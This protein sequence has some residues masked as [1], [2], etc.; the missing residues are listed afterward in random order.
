M[1]NHTQVYKLDLPVWLAR[2][3]VEL[4]CRDRRSRLRLTP[5]VP[6]STLDTDSI[7]TQTIVTIRYKSLISRS[8]KA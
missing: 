1:V 6:P 5:L 8:F 3:G 4:R 2:V 7:H